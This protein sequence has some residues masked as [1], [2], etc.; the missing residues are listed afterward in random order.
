MPV[1]YK[2]ALL[3][4]VVSTAG[5]CFSQYQ[6]RVNSVYLATLRRAATYNPNDTRQVP[7]FTWKFSGVTEL[8]AL[9]QQWRL[10]SV[11]GFG[12]EVSRLINIMH[13]VHNTIR[14]DGT[15]PTNIT[16]AD[17]RTI[18]DAVR[19]RGIGVSCGELATVLNECYLAMGWYSRKVYCFPK[20][21][22]GT[23]NDSHVINAVYAAS[24]KK[25]LWMDPTNDA[26]VMDERGNLLS[27][28]EVR[29]R[30]I[31]GKPLLVNPDANWNR[32]SST[33]KLMYLDDYMAKNLYRLYSPVTS[34]R[35]AETADTGKVVSYIHLLPLDYFIQKPDV[36]KRN[37]LLPGS[38]T[39]HYRTNNPAVFWA[40]PADDED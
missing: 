7:R 39:M 38:A 22:L 27:I 33:T 29:T 35:D 8:A 16:R 37:G 25:W 26:Y 31:R 32:Q 23:D 36:Y 30:L 4:L 9:R 20:D 12:N 17:A 2:T 34:A 6:P 18:M 3:L 21:S 11:G 1:L 5:T 28:E 19:Q 24:L 40:P 15:N 10:D 13:W 14:H